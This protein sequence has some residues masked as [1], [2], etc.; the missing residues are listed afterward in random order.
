MTSDAA[1]EKLSNTSQKDSQSLLDYMVEPGVPSILSKISFDELD[2]SSIAF[3]A[4]KYRCFS[5]PKNAPYA[6][7]CVLDPLIT[8]ERHHGKYHVTV[9]FNI[10]TTILDYHLHKRLGS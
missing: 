2:K 1:P 6:S 8:V 4:V 5:G 7:I 10:E 9:R 3:F